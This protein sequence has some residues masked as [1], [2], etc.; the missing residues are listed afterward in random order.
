MA[1]FSHLKL[2]DQ[3]TFWK[4]LAGREGKRRFTRAP[5]AP[6]HGALRIALALEAS[7]LP[8]TTTLVDQTSLAFDLVEG[9]GKRCGEIGDLFEKR[10]PK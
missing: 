1:C 2:D 3:S 4:Y 9:L 7:L 6:T 5:A 10:I 8:L